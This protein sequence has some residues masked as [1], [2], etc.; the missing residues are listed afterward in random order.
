MSSNIDLFSAAQ[1]Y[2]ALGLPVVP[3]ILEWNDKKQQYD[4][5]NIGSWKK[6][7]IE[8]QTAE[9]FKNLTW[10]KNGKEANAF[11]VILGNKAKN[12]LY[13]TVI[14][15]DV[16][17]NVTEEAIKKGKEIISELPTT[18]IEETANKGYHILYWSRQ[19]VE[20]DAKFH[21]N[22]GVELLADKKLCLMAP[23]LGYKNVGSDIITEIENTAQVF[24]KKLQEKGFIS[25]PKNANEKTSRL[26]AYSFK[27]SDVLDLT[28]FEK[29][30]ETE[31]QGK[32]PIHDST[33]EKNFCVNIKDNTWHCFRHHTGGG[34][35]QYLAMK[36][37]II[38]CEDAT[39]GALKGKKFKQ[40]IDLAIS[41][42]LLDPQ[43]LEQNEIHP[44]LLAK[45]IME[46]YHFVT[47]KETNELYFWIEEEGVYSNKTEQVIK[48]EMVNRLDENFKNRYYTDVSEYIKNSASLVNMDSQNPELLA[49]KN[50]LLNIFTRE[51]KPFSYEI[52][53][54][55]KLDWEYK[56]GVTAKQF[57][58]FLNSVL[59]DDLTAQRRIQQLTGHCLYKKIITETCL[60]L[61][62]KGENGKSILLDVIKNFLGIKNVSSH[63]IQQLC[64]DKFTTAEIKGKLANICA[65]LPHKELMN[66][67]TYKAI[68]SGD[69]VTIYKKHV[70]G[71]QT[72]NP[73]TKFLYSANAIPQITEEE[74]AYA[75]YRRFVFADFK[76]TFNGKKKIPRQILLGMLT[77]PEEMTG[78]LNWALD[79]L[80][81]LK[82][83][84]DITDKPTVDDIRKEYR[85][86]SS[87][88]LAYFDDCV[89]ITDSEDDLVYTDDWFRNYVTYCH[90]HDLT[91]S[92]KNVFLEK[93]ETDL[94]GAYRTKI[95]PAPKENPKSAWRYVKIVQSVPSVPSVPHFENLSAKNKKIIDFKNNYLSKTNSESVEHVE[96]VEQNKPKWQVKEVPQGE[97]CEG[98]YCKH[99]LNVTLELTTPTG[100]KVRRCTICYE[101]LKREY[102]GA[103]FERETQPEMPDF[104]DKCEPKEGA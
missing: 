41:Q 43:A 71:S 92:N 6:W 96:Q 99:A 22:A 64:Y 50:G 9:D 78:I 65:D 74:D 18:R 93:V 83:N 26:N 66:T 103:V 69:A 104:S 67:G 89:T 13:L 58:K 86:R 21:D 84:G 79:G 29:I 37:G 27:I 35:L 56:E 75:W 4:K 11:G 28:K 87:S 1:A 48:R 3:F 14:D 77:T 62:G 2:N 20:T 85:R 72:F 88:Q 60:I 54:T 42:G 94:P 10:T 76:Q 40:V 34:A 32:H 19:K 52:Y 16:K 98:S 45:D 82:K 17:G 68:V 55:S 46:D 30:N 44:I 63:S 24:Y 91:P 33:T 81:E 59:P 61:L 31:Y 8:P 95:R 100:D 97:Q 38:T 90:E 53:I 12:G 101:A 51:L 57:L 36:E 49:V 5:D 15:Y 39:K 102:S 47:D 25:K 7:E 80:A 23:S 70:Q 73:Y